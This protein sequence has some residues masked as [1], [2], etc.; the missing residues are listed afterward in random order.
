MIRRG[1]SLVRGVATRSHAMGCPVGFRSI[2]KRTRVVERPGRR[3]R[4]LAIFCPP[5]ETHR[6]ANLAGCRAAGTVLPR[7]PLSASGGG[8]VEGTDVVL[9]DAAKADADFVLDQIA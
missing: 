9:R 8:G 1:H 5:P 6:V 4:V 3:P 2:P 7:R